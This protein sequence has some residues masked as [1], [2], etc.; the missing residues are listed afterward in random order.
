MDH[1]LLIDTILK[2]KAKLTG[3][4][5]REWIGNGKPMDNGWNDIDIIC[6]K[7]KEAIIAR[8]VLN[9]FPN[10]KL[11]FRAGSTPFYSSKYSANLFRYD[12]EF[13][14]MPPYGKYQEEFLSLTKNKI[15]KFL[16]ANPVGRRLDLEK[17]L[18]SN[19][20]KLVILNKTF[21]LNNYEL[22][23]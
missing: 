7:D 10:I 19:G 4:Y 3:S 15:C 5:I 16:N 20:W 12:G 23:V 13:K 8:E 18:I 1:S 6:P 21:D 22:F 11:D 9:K 2:N 14:I 17:K